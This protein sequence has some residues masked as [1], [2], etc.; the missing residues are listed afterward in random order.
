TERRLFADG[1]FY[2]ADGRA[3]FVFE[4]PRPLPEP[5][6]ARYPLTLLTGRAAAAVWHTQTRTAKSAV[7][8]KLAPQGAYVEINPDD[9]RALKIRPGQTVVVE[10]QRGSVSAKAFVTT[11]VPPG[12]VFLPM[13]DEGTNRLTDA[14]FDPYSRQPAYK[15]C[16]VRVRH[17]E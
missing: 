2:H 9:A 13:H 6:S 8:R 17:E 11:A 4:P 14:V 7:L 12:H 5:A 10:S 15:A 1:R 3:R 16:A